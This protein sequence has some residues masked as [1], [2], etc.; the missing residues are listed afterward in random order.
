[1]STPKT[2]DDYLEREG[3]DMRPA[4]ERLRKTIH[5]VVLRA[6]LEDFEDE[7]EGYET[8][9]GTLCFQPEHPLPAALVRA[10][11]K[12]RIERTKKPNPRKRSG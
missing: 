10:P 2:I 8:S 12:A 5:S 4:L 9:K 6:V 1:M 11:I 7:L 3:D